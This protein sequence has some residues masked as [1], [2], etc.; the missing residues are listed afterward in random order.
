M[1]VLILKFIDILVL[2]IFDLK[3]QIQCPR[4]KATGV[5]MATILCC[6]RWEVFLMLAFKYELDTTTQY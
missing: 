4:C 1:Y 6:T 3:L 5:A 2:E